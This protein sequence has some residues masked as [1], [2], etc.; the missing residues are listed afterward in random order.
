MSLSSPPFS[1][2]VLKGETLKIESGKEIIAIDTKSK[3]TILRI[4]SGTVE[5]LETGTIEIR[6]YNNVIP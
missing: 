6:N 5:I 1:A 3:L 4:S 2:P